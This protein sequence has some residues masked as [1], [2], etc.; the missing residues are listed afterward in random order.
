MPWRAVLVGDGPLHN[1][2]GTDW[3]PHLD[4][5]LVVLDPVRLEELPEPL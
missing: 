3:Q 2:I 1:T 4:D 5:R